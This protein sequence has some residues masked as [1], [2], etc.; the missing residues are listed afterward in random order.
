MLNSASCAAHRPKTSEYNV[1]DSLTLW[2]RPAYRGRTITETVTH[3]GNSN[4]YGYHKEFIPGSQGT[5]PSPYLLTD[6]GLQV[7]Y[8]YH[9][10]S[11][12]IR[13]VM[14]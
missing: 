6:H 7:P 9:K 14:T 8:I 4:S 10:I 12:T 11:S 1:A 2:L 5:N 3:M 13:I